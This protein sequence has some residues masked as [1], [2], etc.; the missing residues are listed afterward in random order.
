M[1]PVKEERAVLK[2]IV[3]VKEVGNK[4]NPSL[5]ENSNEQTSIPD[6]DI[7]ATQ[8]FITNAKK[9]V[10]KIKTVTKPAHEKMKNF[11]SKNS[12]QSSPSGDPGESDYIFEKDISENYEIDSTASVEVDLTTNEDVVDIETQEE[13]IV[14]AQVARER[15][16]SALAEINSLLE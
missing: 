13:W 15:T 7:N 9:S 6:F 4:Q 11:F 14:Q 16:Q 1:L 8:P 2:E 12:G 3:T 10:K 5:N